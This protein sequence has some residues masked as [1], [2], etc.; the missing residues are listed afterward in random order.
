MSMLF[1]RK[2]WLML[3]L[4]VFAGDTFSQPEKAALDGWTWE[5]GAARN[6]TPSRIEPT[7]LQG[8]DYLLKAYVD[9]K[10]KW[11]LELIEYACAT[12]STYDD[13]SGM[14]VSDAKI[15]GRGTAARLPALYYEIVEDSGIKHVA[16][17]TGDKSR[18]LRI[19]IRWRL[20]VPDETSAAEAEL[21]V[22]LAQI[23]RLNH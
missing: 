2:L 15:T 7:P 19:T 12:C 9:E 3:V 20:R 10:R 17:V 14:V 22:L 1:A 4:L 13:P 23:H 16:A 6:W 5:L 18:A 8:K 11:G 21:K